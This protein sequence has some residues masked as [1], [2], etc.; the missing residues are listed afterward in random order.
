MTGERSCKAV[1]DE[2]TDYLEDTLPEAERA[3][4]EAH[5]DDCEW[6]TTYLEQMRA[7]VASL[8]T[9]PEG[10]L[11]ARRRA[12]VLAAFRNRRTK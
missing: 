10:G 2:I 5:L 11:P 3:H 1:I 8:G 9:I 12:D 6:C 7:T 4:V